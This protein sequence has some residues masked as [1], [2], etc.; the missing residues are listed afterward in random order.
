[1]M[2]Q[3]LTVKRN[4][5][6]KADAKVVQ[7]DDYV[8]TLAKAPPT[9]ELPPGYTSVLDPDDCSPWARVVARG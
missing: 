7:T 2:V 4:V 3:K 1:M 5:T 8:L 6:L 9:R